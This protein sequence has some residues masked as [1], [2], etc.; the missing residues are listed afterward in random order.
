[1]RKPKEGDRISHNVTFPAEVT[2]TGTVDWVGSAQ[3]AYIDDNGQRHM[4]MFN[5]DWKTV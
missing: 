5:E 1:M 4:C 3:F 2:R